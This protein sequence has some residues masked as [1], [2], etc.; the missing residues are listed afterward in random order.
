MVLR[1]IGFSKVSSKRQMVIPKEFEDTFQ[2][3]DK[4]VIVQE[5]DA[6]IVKNAK[7]LSKEFEDNI[8]FLHGIDEAWKDFDEGRYYKT[9][10]E[11]LLEDIK[12]W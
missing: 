9:D 4:L 2:E 6:L 10:K 3:G 7:H 5:G 8:K 11:T 12:R 1:E